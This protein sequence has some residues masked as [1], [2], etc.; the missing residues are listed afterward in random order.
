MID[1]DTIRI[2]EA[3][4]RVQLYGIDAPEFKQPCIATDGSEWACG[5]E[6]GLAL[7]QRIAGRSVIC[8]GCG[9]VNSILT[10]HNVMRRPVRKPRDVL[11]AVLRHDK[12]VVFAVAAGAGFAFGDGYHRLH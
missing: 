9:P 7:E 2:G 10:A 8:G 5:H 12:D 3:E 4:I 11:R 6:A 1:A